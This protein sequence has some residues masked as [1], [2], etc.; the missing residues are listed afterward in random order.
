VPLPG[1]NAGRASYPYAVAVLRAHQPRAIKNP[2]TFSHTAK[3]YVSLWNDESVAVVTGFPNTP[4]VASYIPVG[5]HPTALLFNAYQTRL[6]VANSNDDSVSVIDTDSDQEIER[7]NIRLAESQHIGGS[8]EGLALSDDGAKLYVANAHSGTVAVVALGE[9]AQGKRDKVSGKSQVLGFIPTGRYPSAVAVAG[10][11]LF[12]ANGKGTGWENSSV[13]ANNTGQAP[14]APNDRFPTGWGRGA[15][16]GG[17]YSL[18]LVAGTISLLNL[19]TERELAA[20][21]QTSMRKNGLLG[22]KKTRLFP[23]ASPIKHIIYIIRENRTYDQVFGDL[24]RAGNGQKADG[25]PGL[26]IFGAGDAAQRPD[27]DTRLP[28]QNITPN[29]RA[30]ALRFGLLDRFFVNSEASPDGHNWS[31]AAFSSDYVDKAHRWDY[32]GRGRGYD[33]EGFNRLPNV[34]PQRDTPPLFDKP[35][36]GDD[37]INFW[38]RFA[39]DVNGGRDVA[40]PETRYLWDACAQAGLSYHNYGEFVAT[41]SQAELDSINRNKSRTYPD[42]TPTVSAL[43]TKK[44]LESHHSPTFRNFDQNTPDAMTPDSY[45][46]AK[47]SRTDP[48]VSPAH[49]DARARGYS[50][51]SDWL[52]EF[53]GYVADLQAGRGDKLPAFSMVRLPNDHT[54]GTAANF[55]TPQFFVAENDYALGRLVQA[56]SHSPYWKDTAIFVLED[57]AQD[58]PDHVDAHRSPALVISAYNRPG[59]LIHDYHNTVSLIRTME[60]L[61]GLPPMNFLDANA[62]PIDIFHPTPDLRPFDAIL[63]EI[64]LDNLM[65]PPARTAQARYWQQRTLEQDLEHAD[66][67]D[68]A[69]LNQAIWFSV[70]GPREPMPRPVQLPV[71][72]AMRAGMKEEIE[73]ADEDDD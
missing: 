43:P 55:P 28:K 30:L 65:T 38:R 8:P 42:L 25:D 56:V 9:P 7:I 45:R 64:S 61:L 68:A 31:T 13:V 72:T 12:I 51:T 19:P 14:N 59:A 46:A 32:S 10:K 71:F 26:A 39:P 5:R 36:T 6:Y 67:A 11:H 60:L 23:G 17:A 1:R 16:G 52:A 4:Q 22:A 47:I 50:R 70:R 57:D 33:Y 29:A 41:L 37:V 69:T 53:N 66:M 73:E 18:G 24:E 44:T 62:A 34:F 58:G 40:E 35:A 3:A 2:E 54:Q 49:A 21:T 48:L 20:F 63:P 15:G 27:R